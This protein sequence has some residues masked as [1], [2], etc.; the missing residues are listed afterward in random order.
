MPYKP[1]G[2]TFD[3][4]NIGDVFVC[5]SRT[6]TEAD[7]V[8]FAGV[9]GDYNPLHTDEE[10]GKTTPFGSRIAHGVLGLA[11]ATGQANQLGIFEGTTIALMQQTIK[12]VGA[13][14]FGDTIHLELKVA[15]K[16]ESSK[17]DRGVVTFDAYVINQHG[18]NVIEGQWVCL[19][20]R[21][22]A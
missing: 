7:T 10:F 4:F 1:R 18:K 2:L 21:R 13:V 20:A 5:Q 16:K 22:S 19:M 3:Q 17:P 14:K 15:E 9:S 8:N 6:V 12:Y 11:I